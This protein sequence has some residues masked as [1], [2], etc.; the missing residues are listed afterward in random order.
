[1]S[2]LTIGGTPL[3]ARLVERLICLFCAS[4][5]FL[6][7]I[8]STSHAQVQQQVKPKGAEPIP[9]PAVAAILSAF[10]RYEVVGMPEAH[11]MKDVDDF[12]I[13]CLYRRFVR[14]GSEREAVGRAGKVFR[15]GARHPPRPLRLEWVR[16]CGGETSDHLPLKAASGAFRHVGYA[17]VAS[18]S[19]LPFSFSSSAPDG[20]S[21]C[22]TSCWIGFGSSC[23]LGGFV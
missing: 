20:R 23:S 13:P 12:S 18:S 6:T 11:G 4:L 15:A 10:D 2:N 5:L 17:A 22:S 7:A 16:V 8:P 1:M 3:E 21:T 9:E 19:V 14:A